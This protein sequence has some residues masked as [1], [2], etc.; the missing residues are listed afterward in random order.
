MRLPGN[1]SESIKRLNPDVFGV[2]AVP[3]AKPKRDG[4]REPSS[5]DANEKRGPRRLV[6]SLIGFRRIP[7]DD[8]NFN[9]SCKHVR[10]AIA[11][12]FGL[13][14][15]DKRFIWQYSQQHTRGE[16]GILVRIEIE[17]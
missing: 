1:V 7:L 10:D 11:A 16:E 2:G 8:D 12:S 3:P 14:D 13:D 17:P 15:G 5:P 6:V 9:G 4:R